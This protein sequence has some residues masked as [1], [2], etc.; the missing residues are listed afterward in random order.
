MP[1]VMTYLEKILQASADE[2]SEIKKSFVLFIIIIIIN[3]S[4]LNTIFCSD[5][6][7]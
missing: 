4:F 2:Y 7:W 1:I 6:K 3:K 5:I